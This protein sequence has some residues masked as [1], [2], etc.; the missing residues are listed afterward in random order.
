MIQKSLIG[1]V[2]LEE[3]EID[4]IGQQCNAKNTGEAIQMP[5][6]HE[7]LVEVH[8][9]YERASR[10]ASDMAESYKKAMALADQLSE[11]CKKTQTEKKEL[12]DGRQQK[13][14]SDGLGAKR[15]D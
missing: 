6:L 3:Q 14:L 4:R 5:P 11:Q 2:E 8:K 13:E 12:S 9:E 1:A 15:K 7:A 10:V